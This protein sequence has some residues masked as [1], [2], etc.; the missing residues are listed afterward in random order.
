MSLNCSLNYKY[1]NMTE[2]AHFIVPCKN[3][4]SKKMSL[5]YLMITKQV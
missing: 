4:P 2:L 5:K 3:Q 1:L